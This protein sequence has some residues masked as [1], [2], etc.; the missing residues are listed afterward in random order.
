[1]CEGPFE[2][3]SALNAEAFEWVA[4]ECS[5]CTWVNESQASQTSNTWIRRIYNSRVCIGMCEDKIDA[6]SPVS[7]SFPSVEKAFCRIVSTYPHILLQTWFCKRLNCLTCLQNVYCGFLAL[8][9]WQWPVRNADAL[10]VLC[11]V[12][13]QWQEYS[14][15]TFLSWGWFF[16][17]STLPVYQMSTLLLPTV[18]TLCRLRALVELEFFVI[19]MDIICS[20]MFNLKIQLKWELKLIHD[21]L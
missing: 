9:L 8:L 19:W 16:E 14:S 10:W 7:R 6:A 15:L 18:L 17:T 5:L 20:V 2:Y 3:D 1:M 11:F 4:A 13:A 12:E 21:W